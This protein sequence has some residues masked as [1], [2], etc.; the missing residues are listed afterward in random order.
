MQHTARNAPAA[1]QL[2]VDHWEHL[3][4]LLD[5][6]NPD[7]T[8]PASRAA[9]LRDLDQHDRDEALL[10]FQH[11]QQLTTRH[12][13]HGRVFYECQHCDYV[14]EGRAHLPRPDRAAVQLGERPVP[15]RLH[16]VDACRAV[17]AALCALADEI[18]ADI[19]RAPITPP[20]RGNANDP[21]LRDLALLATRDD[22]DPRRWH[23]NMR[24]R[25]APRAAA[26]LL[27][28]WND[29]PGPCRKLSGRHR[30]VIAAVAREAAARVERTIGGVDERRT[31]MVEQPCP[32][33]SSELLLHTGGG[34][35]DKVT[36]T[37]PD[38]G[39]P[40]GLVHGWRTWSTPEQLAG[41][42]RDIE[43]AA[44]R[45]KRADDRARQRAAARARQDTAA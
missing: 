34:E 33:C 31:E 24:G 14:G 36:C 30:I 39:A 37:G 17:E 6:R 5:T 35:P 45:R 29:E 12:D 19:Q 41:L 32:W 42:R 16:V 21:A 20:R 43:A 7:T 1:L 22:A 23:Y 27:A 4:A 18:A 10:A 44:R 9:Y 28:R 3:R 40:V 2:I 15:L 38:C 11:A 13:E 8:R 26:W 25:T